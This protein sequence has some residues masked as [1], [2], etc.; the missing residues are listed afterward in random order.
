MPEIQ[1]CKIAFIGGGNMGGAMIAGLLAQ[2]S[3]SPQNVVVS[4]PWD[5]NRK[6]VEEQHGV[7]TTTSNA[8]A[9]AGAD[10]LVLAVKPQVAKDVCRDLAASWGADRELPLVVSIVAGVTMASLAAWLTP[11]EGGRKPRLVRVMPNTPAL[12][13]EGASGAY[14]GDGVSDD[15]KELVTLLAG[16]FSKVTEW[17]ENEGLIDVVTGVS[18]RFLCALRDPG[19]LPMLTPIVGSGPAYF[20]AMVEHMVTSATALGMP[21][22]Q[23]ERLAKQTCLGAGKMLVSQS[24]S[25]A[26]LRINVTSPKGTTEAALKSFNESGFQEIVDKAVRACTSRAEELGKVLGEQA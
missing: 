18:G 14:A 22:E 25:P 2:G 17:V 21:R 8:E 7:R 15:E 13:G 3:T 9:A 26:Q 20:F 10:V 11:E 23:A 16:A 5:V 19:E 12:V 24:E 4:E 1:S 6:K